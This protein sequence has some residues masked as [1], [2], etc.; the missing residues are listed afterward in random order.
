MI[1][2]YADRVGATIVGEFQEIESGKRHENRPE[3]KK[4]LS[5]ARRNRATLAVAKLDRLARN[6]AFVSTLLETPGVEFKATDFPDASRMMIQMLAVFGEYEREMISR[7]TKDALA[8]R[9]ARGLPLGRPEN[10]NRGE[11]NIAEENKAK[12]R[13]EAERLR[14]VI[15]QLKS[16]GF[17]SVRAIAAELDARGYVTGRGAKFHPTA[18][19]RILNRL[20]AA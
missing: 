4:A 11:S 18:V 9:A 17:A 1:A 5:L 8:A 20:L 10:L 14:P 7:R 19:A 13:A 3:L 15:V 6:V 12:A 2:D 16:E